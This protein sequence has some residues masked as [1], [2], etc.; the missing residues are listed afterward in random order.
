[1]ILGHTAPLFNL[2]NSIGV[3]E[4]L[5]FVLFLHCLFARC[6]VSHNMSSPVLY[7]QLLFL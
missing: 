1:M 6:R 3:L 5:G 7:N 4:S 2:E